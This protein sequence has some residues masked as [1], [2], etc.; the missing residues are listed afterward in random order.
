MDIGVEERFFELSIDL[1]CV[2]G[3]DGVFRRLN[4]AWEATLGFRREELIARPFIEFVH[5]DD[6][7]RTLARNG[8]VRAGDL[9]R[10]FENRYLSKDRGPRW[11]RWTSRPDPANQVIYGIARDITAEKEAA[12]ELTTL[13]ALLPI[14]SYCKRV[15]D[16]QQYWRSVDEYLARHT[17]I[18]FS[19]GVCPRC[20][21]DA[22]KRERID[23]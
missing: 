11:L 9:N 21:E 19:H 18:R 6:R 1:L 15:R 22:V 12:A 3:F 10:G 14:C 7:A 13:R 4:P 23:E 16:D 17:Q 8:A 2:L 20:F 5:P